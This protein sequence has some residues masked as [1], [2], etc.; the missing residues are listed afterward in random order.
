MQTASMEMDVVTVETEAS[1]LPATPASRGM[2]NALINTIS[3]ERYTKRLVAIYAAIQ[4][5]T[6]WV[7]HGVSLQIGP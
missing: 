2:P 1:Q 6:L 7:G 4:E 5:G 3:M